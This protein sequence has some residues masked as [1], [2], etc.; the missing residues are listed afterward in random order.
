MIDRTRE[1]EKSLGFEEKKL[2]RMKLKL[3]YFKEEH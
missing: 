2:K 1:L 3:L